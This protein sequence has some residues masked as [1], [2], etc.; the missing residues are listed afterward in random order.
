M[1]VRVCDIPNENW[2]PGSHTDHMRTHTSL[3][4]QGDRC[5][6]IQIAW[7]SPGVRIGVKGLQDGDIEHTKAPEPSSSRGPGF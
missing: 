4:L 2:D 6:S 1:W 7:E 5:L 3:Q